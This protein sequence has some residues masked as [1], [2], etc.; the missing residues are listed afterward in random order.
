MGNKK[1]KINQNEYEIYSWK[2]KICNDSWDAYQFAISRPACRELISNII[3]T[4]KEKYSSFFEMNLKETT[5]DI[6]K[7]PNYRYEKPHSF[8]KIEIKNC[9][10]NK[11]LEFWS[12][13]DR[14]VSG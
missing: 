4:Q 8:R 13:T 12:F 2:Y 6:L 14:Y 11:G 7:I 3:M 1:I 5:K 9:K 10:E